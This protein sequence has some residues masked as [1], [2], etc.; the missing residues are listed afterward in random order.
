MLINVSDHSEVSNKE[1]S[2]IFVQLGPRR[3]RGLRL[4]RFILFKAKIFFFLTITELYLSEL[5]KK[6]EGSFATNCS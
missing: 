1:F 2:L 6:S 4:L 3:N 5:Q